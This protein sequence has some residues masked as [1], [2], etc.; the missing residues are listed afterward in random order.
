MRGGSRSSRT[1]RWDAMDAAVRMTKRAARGRRS[2]VVLTPRRWRQVG[3]AT[4]YR[5]GDG[6]KKARSPR[7]A[8]RKPLKPLRREGRMI[9][10]HLWRR[11][12]CAFYF[13]HGATGAAGTRS[14]LRPHLER[15]C[16]GITRALAPRE[17]GDLARRHCERSEAIQMSEHSQFWIASSLRSSQ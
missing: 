8:R 13:A 1:L 3:D 11:H 2:R 16:R 15:R 4:S 14:S 12:S 5:A 10:V 7:R 6:G 17:C 9:R